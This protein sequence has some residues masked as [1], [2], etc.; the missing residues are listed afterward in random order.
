MDRLT[1]VETALGA[2]EGS[3]IAAG[4]NHRPAPATASTPVG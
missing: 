4:S 2:G 1:P 3:Q